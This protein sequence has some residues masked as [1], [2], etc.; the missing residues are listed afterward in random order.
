MS[1][2]RVLGGWASVG[3][4][5]T[6]PQIE[7]TQQA[8]LGTVVSTHVHLRESDDQV[9]EPSGDGGHRLRACGSPKSQVKSPAPRGLGAEPAPRRLIVQQSGTGCQKYSSSVRPSSRSRM[10]SAGRRTASNRRHR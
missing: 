10:A 3:R 1:P 7:V 2:G 6:V 8:D 4:L 5:R 9:S